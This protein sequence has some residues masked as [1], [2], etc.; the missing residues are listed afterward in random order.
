MCCASLW[1]LFLANCH[2]FHL[3]LAVLCAKRNL[4]LP[5][6]CNV[7]LFD[8]IIRKLEGWYW[9][10]KQHLLANPQQKTLSIILLLLLPSPSLCSVRFRVFNPQINLPL[11]FAVPYLKKC[12][13]QNHQTICKYKTHTVQGH[14]DCAKVRM[15][16]EHKNL[17]S[18]SQTETSQLWPIHVILLVAR[19][20]NVYHN[21]THLSQRWRI[22]Q[23]LSNLAQS[24]CWVVHISLGKHPFRQRRMA[25][26]TAHSACDLL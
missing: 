22:D 9:Y 24:I 7:R 4:W 18:G 15:H 3:L 25:P 26:R 1:R 13:T 11:T 2:N 8:I 16:P 6:A 14:I 12:K 5:K 17:G 20:K 10:I 19:Q 23:Q 21:F